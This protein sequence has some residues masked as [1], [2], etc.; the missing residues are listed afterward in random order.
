[1]SQHTTDNNY[2]YVP[3][4]GWAIAFVVLFSLSAIVHTA[5]ATYS[6]YWIVYPTLV[7]GAI[8]EIIG[9]SARLWSSQNVYLLTPFL[10]QISS[11]IIGPV[12]FSAYCYILLGMAIKR[13]GPRYSVLPWSWYFFTFIGADLISIVLQ[14][15]GGGQASSSAASGSPTQSATNIMVAG[16]IFQLVSMVVFLVLGIDFLLRATNK[17]PYAFQ[18]RRIARRSDKKAAAKAAKNAEE[19]V[20]RSDS[21]GTRVGGEERKELVETIEAE[22]NL[23]AWWILLGGVLL[24]SVM[25]ILRGLYRSVELVQGWNGVIIQTERYQNC[26]D[27]IPML[28]T[29]LAFNFIHP[30]FLL[31]KKLTRRGYH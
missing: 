31:P 9:W 24:A 20:I 2:G 6:K 19:G 11:L 8:G 25:I 14:G 7:L 26:L 13:L 29:L 12:F 22:E 15:V 10:M 5:Q 16:I 17:R 23:T 21:D 3:S 27:G 28:I 1:M 4:E 30:M 18:E